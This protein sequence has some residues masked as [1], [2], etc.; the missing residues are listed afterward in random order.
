MRHQGTN[1]N[2]EPYGGFYVEH[3]RVQL[4]AT[5]DGKTRQEFADECDINTLMARYEKS[6]IV[7]HVNRA[8]PQYFDASDIPDL[9]QALAI[10]AHA[11]DAFMSLPAK[12]RKE[13]DN[14]PVQFVKYAE[15]PANVDQMREWGLAAPAPVPDAPMRVEVVNAAPAVENAP[16]ASV[17]PANGQG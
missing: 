17:S 1:A 9:A 2:G 11:E 8:T 7:S 13:F 15:D 12:V 4:D 6:G 10:V 3:K 5:K 16:A 14:D